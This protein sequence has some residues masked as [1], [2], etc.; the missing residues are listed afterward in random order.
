MLTYISNDE[1]PLSILLTN[2]SRGDPQPCT[3]NPELNS[4][5]S[6]N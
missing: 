6:E 2:I 3:W 4:E 5:I 1:L